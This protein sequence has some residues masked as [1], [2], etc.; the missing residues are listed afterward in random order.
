MKS[1]AQ[2]ALLE[3][4]LKVIL[5]VLLL[6]RVGIVGIAVSTVLAQLSLTTWYVPLKACKLTG[7]T[8]WSYLSKIIIPALPAAI[9]GSVLGG[10]TLL[11]TSD[12]WAQILIGAP[13]SMATYTAIYFYFCLSL[14]ERQWLAGKSQR[15]LRMQS[16]V[17]TSEAK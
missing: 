15:L 12:A 10:L 5:A 9:G 11:I 17:E 3:G 14:E 7:D 13:L 6:P 2:I 8:L 4:G 16:P 1:I